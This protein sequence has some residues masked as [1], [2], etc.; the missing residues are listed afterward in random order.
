MGLVFATASIGC[1]TSA[2]SSP[3]SDVSTDDDNEIRAAEAAN[4]APLG[5]EAHAKLRELAPKV[6][7]GMFGEDSGGLCRASFRRG[8]AA[9]LSAEEVL[10][11]FQ[12]N[13]A[14]Q[15]AN[16]EFSFKLQDRNDTELWTSFEETQFDEEGV[17]AARAIKEIFTGPNVK[18]MAVMIPADRVPIGAS[19][20]LIGAM[21]DGSLLVLRGDVGGMSF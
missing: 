8:P 14:E 16:S 10:R 1:S 4:D 3:S 7:L 20:F 11:L 15:L 6:T 17:A 18:E 9:R 2:E 5:R 21:K 12:F 13:V 19:V